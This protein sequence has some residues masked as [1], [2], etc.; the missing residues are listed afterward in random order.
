[1]RT[2]I[3]RCTKCGTK[4]RVP[5]AREGVPRCSVCHTGLP[6]IV[7]AEAADF[8]AVVEATVP[9]LVDMWAEWCGPCRTV[10]PVVE[11]LGRSHAGR[12][13]IVKLD[14]EAAPAI[15]Q[16]HG[17]M[18]IPTLLLLRDGQE[19]D[20]AVGALPEPALRAWLDE[21]LAA[22]GASHPAQSGATSP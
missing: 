16:R 20:R 11:A 12:L 17:V 8:D 1:M 7:D 2:T 9:V 14:I 15:A 19:V 18:S 10:S 4:N 21:K 5:V 3:V 22:T 6:W 13:K